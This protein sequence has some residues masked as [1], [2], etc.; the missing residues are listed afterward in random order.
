MNWRLIDV[1]KAERLPLLL[2]ACAIFL[3]L[4][5]Y[6]LLRPVRDAMA[7]AGGGQHLP[8]MTTATFLVTLALSPLIAALLDRWPRWHVVPAFYVALSAQLLLFYASYTD[9]TTSP[10]WARVFFIWLS[11][12]NLFVTSLF[13]SAMV[14]FF[15]S[16]QSR[17]LFGLV[18][19]GGSAGAIVGPGL[20]ALLAERVGVPVLV[21]VAAALLVLGAGCLWS[22]RSLRTTEAAAVPIDRAL[23]GTA[24]QGLTRTFTEPYLLTIA[25]MTM[26]Y[27]FTSTVLYF[28]QTEI[29][30]NA[31]HET[32][33]RT[34]WFARNDGL[35][36]M[37]AVLLQLLLTSTV[38][39]RFGP[40]GGLLTTPAVT[41][42]GAV[43]L[44]IE[45]SLGL[46][47]V[48][49]IARR[50]LHFAL[51]R[52]ARENL[53]AVLQPEDKYK[54]KNTIDTVI[55]RAND[56]A[57]GWGYR[58]LAQLSAAQI[59]LLSAIAASV[60]WAI[61]AYRAA[62]YEREQRRFKVD[63]HHAA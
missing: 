45:P 62:R 9:A 27:S 52:P 39:R 33:Q 41:L 17:R 56:A 25:L 6:T 2:S 15:N 59:P 57:S 60:I 22:M 23:T 14:D 11:V 30:G 10:I 20:T 4:A 49:Q 37:A 38:L 7:V 54:A 40:L 58:G 42:L 35:A 46:L 50:A 61:L 12:F 63:E 19:A 16:E 48:V 3:L 8:W 31:I 13:W 18:A 51:E 26:L 36:N 53:F 44:V 47:A 43:A 29:V 32:A 34:A 24:W 28:E 55:Y 21:L 5:G 1:R